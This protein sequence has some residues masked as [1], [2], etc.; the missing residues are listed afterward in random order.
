DVQGATADADGAF[1]IALSPDTYY[2]FN[3][4][5]G[6]ERCRDQ[7]RVIVAGRAIEPLKLVL[8]PARRIHGTLTGADNAPIPNQRVSLLW[9]DDESHGKLPPE[10]QLP[11]PK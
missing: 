5:A 4:E 1:Q 8:Q 11:N 7:K 2:V 9:R 3:A 10:E 6:I